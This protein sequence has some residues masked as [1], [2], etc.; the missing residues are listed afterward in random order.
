M[1]LSKLEIGEKGII[2]AN[3]LAGNIRRRLYDLGFTEGS[4]IECV[5]NSIFSNPRA[6]LVKGAVIALRN[7]DASRIIV[8]Q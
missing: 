1:P 8:K 6:Y 3:C 4:E 5:G 2:A 7:T